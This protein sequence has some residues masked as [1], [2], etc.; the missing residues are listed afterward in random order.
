MNKS[1]KT[2]VVGMLGV[3]LTTGA[4]ATPAHAMSGIDFLKQ[5]QQTQQ[6]QTQ[7]NKSYLHEVDG[8]VATKEDALKY[9]GWSVVNGNANQILF[10]RGGS[11]VSGWLG[12]GSSWSYFD[13]ATNY[14]VRNQARVIDGK[15]YYFREDGRMLHDSYK[16]GY[17][18]GSDGAK[19][20]TYDANAYGNYTGLVRIGKMVNGSIALEDI[21]V[22]EY[23]NRVVQGTI[24]ARVDAFGTNG[25]SNIGHSLVVYSV[26]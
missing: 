12:S 16:D 6:Y 5:N 10:V 22:Q 13:P 14:L 19:T 25:S 2:L 15:E 8:L 4:V 9:E 17:Y 24:K 26:D 20:S 1:I 18:Y 7:V 21:T 11:F 3:L 23:E